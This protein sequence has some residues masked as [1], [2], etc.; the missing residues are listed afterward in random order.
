LPLLDT[1]IDI[2]SPPVPWM[3]KC[4]F[5]R[6]PEALW[7]TQSRALYPDG[8][9]MGPPNDPVQIGIRYNTQ[10]KTCISFRE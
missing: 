2:C 3:D 4:E 10:D 7:M 5:R 8:T 9:L 1:S 6:R